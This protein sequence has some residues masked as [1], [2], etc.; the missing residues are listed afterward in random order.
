MTSKERLV[1]ELEQIPDFL[2]EEVLDFARFLK[3]KHLQ[4]RL[5]VTRLSEASLAKDWLSPEEEKAW[6]DL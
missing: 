3:S 5:E 2:V 6:Q 1:Q 4:E